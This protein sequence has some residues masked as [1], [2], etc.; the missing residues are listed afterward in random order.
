MYEIGDFFVCK[1]ILYII[2]FIVFYGTSTQ[3][4]LFFTTLKYIFKILM[5]CM[6]IN[7]IT[8]PHHDLNTTTV[9]MGFWPLRG[10]VFYLPSTTPLGFFLD[11]M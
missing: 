1:L 7:H 4:D 3:I 6:D 9:S 11:I 8:P 5:F 10:I 2:V